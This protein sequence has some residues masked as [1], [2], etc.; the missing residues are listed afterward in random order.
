[1]KIIAL[2]HYSRTGKDTI[3]NALVKTLN[4]NG[5]LRAKKISFAWKLKDICHQL[6]AWAGVREPEYYETPEGELARTV[7]LVKLA[8]KKYPEG[9]TVVDLWIDFGTPAV[10]ENVYEKAWI[11]YVLQTDHDCEVLVI[12]DLRFYNEA[13]AIKEAGGT[14]IKVVR[15]GFMPRFSPADL[16]LWWYTGWDAIVGT[17]GEMEELWMVAARL[18]EQLMRGEEPHFSPIKTAKGYQMEAESEVPEA[19]LDRFSPKF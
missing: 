3:A 9:P 11:Q 5:Q 19:W 8:N 15:P 10:R 13:V 16:N 12:P 1:M 2:G 7:K 14:L 4:E 18:A 17:S 6:F